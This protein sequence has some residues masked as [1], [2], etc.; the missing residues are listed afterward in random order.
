[1]IGKT[2]PPP[3]SRRSETSHFGVISN[4]LLALFLLAKQDSANGTNDQ[5]KVDS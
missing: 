4:K 2:P 1:M 5:K 3:P